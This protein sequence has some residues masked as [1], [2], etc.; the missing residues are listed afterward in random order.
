[1]KRERGCRLDAVSGY[2]PPLDSRDLVASHTC[3][4]FLRDGLVIVGREEES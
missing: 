3:A 2:L 4:E 1:M